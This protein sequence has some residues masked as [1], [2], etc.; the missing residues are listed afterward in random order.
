MT[1]KFYI[2]MILTSTHMMQFGF[3]L[4]LIVHIHDHEKEQ[5]REA[6]SD[7]FKCMVFKHVVLCVGEANS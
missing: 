1:Q 7:K 3:H 2:C 4:L 5:H 6:G